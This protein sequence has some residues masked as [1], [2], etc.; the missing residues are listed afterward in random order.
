MNDKPLY[1]GILRDY[2]V[3]E[4]R[5][6]DRR[7]QTLK[8]I[9]MHLDA[10]TIKAAL[11]LVPQLDD[12]EYEQN[13][14][15]I[16]EAAGVRPSVL[17]KLRRQAEKQDNGQKLQGR[18]LSLPEP[19]PAAEPQD[20]AK[21]LDD[22][23]K[24][25][26]RFVVADQVS[27]DA[28][29]LWCV[30]A[31]IAQKAPCCPNI[32]FSSAVKAC[33]KSTALDV[34]SRL[35][36]KPLSVASI[37]VAALFR[38]VEL[39]SPTL[40]IDEAD[41]IFRQ[42]D[43]L[44]TLINAGFTR[45]AARVVRI[46]GDE[47]EPRLFNVY[48][49]KAIALIGTLPDTI[50]SRSVIIRMRRRLPDEPVERLRSDKD[51]GFAPLASR[52]ARWTQDNADKILAQEPEIDPSLSDRQADVWRELL[53][54]ADTVG[55]EWP[56]RARIAAIELCAKQS[57]DG[58]LSIR[59]LADLK[60]L[61]DTDPSRG[62][63]TS[64]VI[65][66]YL[67]HLEPSP[68]P[69]YA[70][71]RG[72]DA[73]RLA[74]L[75][76]KFD[77]RSKNIVEGKQR[78]KGYL[79]SSFVDVFARYL[80]QSRTSAT[81]EDNSLQDK[82]IESS[83]KVAVAAQTRYHIDTLPESSGTDPLPLPYPLPNNAMLDKE[84]AE[85]VADVRVDGAYI[86]NAIE[87]EAM[88]NNFTNEDLEIV[89]SVFTR[90]IETNKNGLCVANWRLSCMAEGVSFEAFD[91]IKAYYDTTGVYHHVSRGVVATG[92]PSTQEAEFVF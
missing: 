87:G 42:N 41:A 48:A 52:I 86:K 11:W 54:I 23:A 80:P 57:D 79:V 64:A 70:R 47:L 31:H 49:P 67:N 13:R 25:V 88:S 62:A 68:W 26:R 73:N 45:S 71:G 36:P 39:L 46:V 27:I 18:A 24:Q 58:D 77:V 38:T 69:D 5:T 50:E 29:T 9:E 34:V 59:L 7:S 82:N 81:N 51:Q 55:G 21:L 90:L 32:V 74:R 61:F 8:D 65:V 16:A 2:G 72:M 44:R 19:V 35:V 12:L 76:A 91:K 84:I 43:E 10:G 37:S 89:G 56:Q 78:L 92:K 33:G 53:R 30:F 75:L 4:L 15:K 20:G 66:E 3:S 14:A 28:I 83:G 6:L 60:T 40:L 17:D 63:W 1:D 85:K 22:V